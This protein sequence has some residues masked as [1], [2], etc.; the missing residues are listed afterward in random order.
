MP[1][2]VA[3][4]IAVSLGL[5]FGLLTL[6]GHGARGYLSARSSVRL[7]AALAF[8]P[9]LLVAALLRPGWAVLHFAAH[10]PSAA[11][12]GGA[13]VAALLVPF[14]YERAQSLGALS[15]GKAIVTATLP[16]FLGIG[17]LLLLHRR[18]LMLRPPIPRVEEA[19]ALFGSPVGV[20]FV[21][22]DLLLVV[23]VALTAF[24]LAEEDRPNEGRTRVVR[25]ISLPP[26]VRR[27]NSVANKSQTAPSDAA[28]VV[29]PGSR[30]E[31]RRAGDTTRRAR[32]G[33]L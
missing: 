9:S 19:E 12:L 30:T 13:F 27:A 23:A 2:L 7:F 16:G 32:R 3:P 24:A 22:V 14:V 21:L 20:G 29:R 18:T 6:D 17:L 31:A 1:L 4:L 8:F 10:P 26:A 25:K 28:R 15:R 33:D 11:L 5:C